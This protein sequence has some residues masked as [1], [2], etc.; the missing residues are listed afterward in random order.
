VKLP[1]ILSAEEITRFFE[2]VP[3]SQ[4]AHHPVTAYAV[5]M[6]VSEVIHLN[7][8]DIDRIAMS[9]SHP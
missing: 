9:A 3:K 1:V 8:T 2:S 6:R 4:A 5:G 7:V